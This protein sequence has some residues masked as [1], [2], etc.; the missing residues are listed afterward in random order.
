MRAGD[1]ELLILGFSC[2]SVV[3]TLDRAW[4]LAWLVDQSIAVGV[5]RGINSLTPKVKI[6]LLNGDLL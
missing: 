3:I 6:Q 2:L 5:A 4:L 1:F